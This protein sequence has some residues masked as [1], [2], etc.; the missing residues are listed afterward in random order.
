MIEWAIENAEYISVFVILLLC[1]AVV[2]MLYEE[3]EGE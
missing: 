1:L 3:L 2:L